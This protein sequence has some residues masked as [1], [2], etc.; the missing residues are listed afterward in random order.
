MYLVIH[1][2]TRKAQ[3]EGYEPWGDVISSHRTLSGA[4]REYRR[5]NPHLFNRR[6][7]EAHGYASAG[8]F[9]EIVEVDRN[10][11]Y[12]ASCYTGGDDE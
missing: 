3:H 11:Y 10:G 6:W 5:R 9:D 4:Q 2:D 8:T 1:N 12:V 7:A